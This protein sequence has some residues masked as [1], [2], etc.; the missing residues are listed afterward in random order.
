MR[1][2]EIAEAILALAADPERA[3][4]IAGDLLEESRGR[5]PRFWWLVAQTMLLQGARQFRTAPFGMLGP[6]MLAIAVELLWVVV[7]FFLTFAGLLAA[8]SVD[9]VIFHHDLPEFLF[10]NRALHLVGSLLYSI[11]VP[12]NVG[13][14]IARRYPGRECTAIVTVTAVNGALLFCTDSIAAI[15]WTL[16]Y[17]NL[18][19]FAGAALARYRSLRSN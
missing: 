1:R 16:L 5:A 12:L 6:A 9:K 14:W 13:Q 15:A 11:L 7:V 4:A 19:A 18:I 10:H 2:L 8:E 3:T 17:S